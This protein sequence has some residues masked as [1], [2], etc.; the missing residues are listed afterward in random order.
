MTYE[1]LLEKT[2][3]FDLDELDVFLGEKVPWTGAACLWKEGDVWK[4][5]RILSPKKTANFTGTEDEMCTQMFN[6]ILLKE[7]MRVKRKE[8]EKKMS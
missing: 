8:R 3:N 7:M 6:F 4:I 1:E 5:Q 2:K